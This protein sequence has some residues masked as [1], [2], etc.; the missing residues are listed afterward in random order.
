MMS[1]TKL[2]NYTATVNVSGS[3]HGKSRAKS[4]CSL[5]FSR[6]PRSERVEKT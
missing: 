4:V 3:V 5:F 6:K 1:H 2:S